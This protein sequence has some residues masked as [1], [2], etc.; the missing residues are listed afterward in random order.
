MKNINFNNLKKDNYNGIEFISSNST[1]GW[2]IAYSRIDSISYE[3]HL[4]LDYEFPNYDGNII[5]L[6]HDDYVSNLE[7]IIQENLDNI[8]VSFK[9]IDEDQFNLIVRLNSN[10]EVLEWGNYKNTEIF[11]NQKTFLNLEELI[12]KIDEYFFYDYFETY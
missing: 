8:V 7:L 6:R 5:V 3:G 2:F 4:G 9:I 1:N 10:L 11:I 12:M